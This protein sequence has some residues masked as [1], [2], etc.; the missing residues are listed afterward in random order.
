MNPPYL[1]LTANQAMQ[2]PYAKMCSLLLALKMLLKLRLRHEGKYPSLEKYIFA[3]SCWKNYFNVLTAQRD[4][5]L[6]ETWT[7]H[8]K[9][10]H[11]KGFFA[12]YRAK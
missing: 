6:D 5:K 3:S 1:S 4:V 9:T 12:W 7:C 8:T 2:L 10:Q 11:P